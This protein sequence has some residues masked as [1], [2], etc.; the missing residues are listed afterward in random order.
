M[1]LS[2]GTS[3]RSLL[4][5]PI[6][7]QG[8]GR[9]IGH[10]VDSFLGRFEKICQEHKSEKRAKSFALIFYD[11]SDASI[12]AILKDQG[13]FAKLDRLSGH[14]IS[15]FYL[16][17]KHRGTVD[18]FNAELMAKLGL[19]NVTLPCV[20][21]FKL[22]K[23]GFSDVAVAEL[24]ST[25]LIH[26]FPALNEVFVRYLADNNQPIRPTPKSIRWVTG[27][28]KF[29]SLEVVRGAIRSALGHLLF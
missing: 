25:D 7:E 27:A 22:D 26:A 24:D 2:E 9:G 16:H 13:V 1:V 15:I 6:Y 17:A 11:F 3:T 23:G 29:I 28:A 21:F 12:R 10:N 8:S 5:I 4:V 20:V 18:R 19:E 14:D